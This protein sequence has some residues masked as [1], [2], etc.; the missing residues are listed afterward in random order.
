MPKSAVIQSFSEGE[1]QSLFV[2]CW[3]E[4]LG[5]AFLIPKWSSFP[6]L[7]KMQQK[8][9]FDNNLSCISFPP[10]K[11][12]KVLA[13]VLRGFPASMKQNLV[14]ESF[15]FS[16]SSASQN[17]RDNQPPKKTKELCFGALP[18]NYPP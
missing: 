6:T 14:K 10:R 7:V 8:K 1:N 9:S 5:N 18:R 4:Y 17:F 12:R 2:T 16:G 15:Q 13:I 3:G 11:Y